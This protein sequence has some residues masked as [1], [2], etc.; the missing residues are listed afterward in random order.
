M[1][2]VEKVVGLTREI[3]IHGA[4]QRRTILRGLDRNRIKIQRGAGIRNG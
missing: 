2:Q 3:T 1:L 4:S